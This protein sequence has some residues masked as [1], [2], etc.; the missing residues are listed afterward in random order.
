MWAQFSLTPSLAQREGEQMLDFTHEQIVPLNVLSFIAILAAGIQMKCSAFA[1]SH[2]S[3]K[4][5]LK[6]FGLQR[7]ILVMSFVQNEKSLYMLQHKE[8]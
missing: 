3:V 1:L 5:A 6:F 2:S 7:T 4:R 8:L